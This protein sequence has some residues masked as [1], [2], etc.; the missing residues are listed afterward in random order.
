MSKMFFL[1][2]S[3]IY[4]AT[5]TA[6]SAGVAGY[7]GHKMHCETGLITNAAPKKMK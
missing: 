1:H 7:E 2:P 4:C 3:R 6:R 5:F